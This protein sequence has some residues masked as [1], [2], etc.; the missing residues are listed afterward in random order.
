MLVTPHIAPLSDANRLGLD[1]RL[2]ALK[3]PWPGRV[4]DGHIHINSVKAGRTLMEV[5]RVFGI[6]R[7]WSQS[8]LE[9]VDALR[10]EFGDKFEFIAVP[11]YAA[12]ARDETFTTDWFKRLDAFREKGVKIAKFWGAPRGRDFHPSILLD[13]PTRLA[14]MKHAKSLGMALMFHVADPDTWFLT[15]YKDAQ[16]YGTKASHYEVLERIL[17]EYAD[18]PCLAAH[19]AGDPEH[20]DHLQGLL[21]RHANLYMDISATKWMVRELSHQPERFAQFCRDNPGRLMWGTDNVVADAGDSFE[22]YASRYWSMRALMETDY[23]GMCPIVDPD[24]SLVDPTLP[25]DSTAAMHGARL[26]PATLEMLYHR[27]AEGFAR[28][29]HAI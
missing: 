27:A 16:R 22:L 2:E 12:K 24:L 7:F 11:N 6:E 9:D 1:Y 20:L 17:D 25:S 8:Q 4:I 29:I 23:Q 19:L 14:A 10:G 28:R 21:D 5:A 15:H 3:L 13:H 18:T 26:D